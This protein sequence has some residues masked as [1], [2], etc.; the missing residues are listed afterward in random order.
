MGNSDADSNR[1]GHTRKLY[2]TT[3]DLPLPSGSRYHLKW[4]K[5]YLP[6]LYSWAGSINDPF[7]AN[8]K[9]AVEVEVIWER[10]FPDIVLEVA[11]I[12]TVLRVVRA[13]SEL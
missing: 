4:T 6:Q 9:M 8:G 5:E 2:P 11:D 13:L 1:R 12:P 7:G 10:T 3:S